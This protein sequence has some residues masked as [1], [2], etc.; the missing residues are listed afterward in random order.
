MKKLIK[1]LFAAVS[2]FLLLTS[3]TE[4]GPVGPTGPQGPQGPAGPSI[5]P[6][7]FEFEID[8]NQ[9]NGFE[10]FQ[11]IPSQI[12][13]LES[14]VMLAYVFEDYIPED[15]L[16]VWRKLPVI[17]FNSN[18]TLLLDFDFTFVD[19]R[20]FLDANYNLG[21][22]DEFNGMLMR[23]VHVPA[24]FLSLNKLNPQAVRQTETIKE[25]ESLLGTE[26]HSL[27]RAEN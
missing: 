25:L 27:E 10:Y 19:M 2:I 21:P 8:L 7:S 16:E 13:F 6:T 24:D 11:D 12:D 18:G 22:A 4:R 26:I 9:A 23:A 15:D 20:F 1:F 17:E 14:D 3:C 5:L